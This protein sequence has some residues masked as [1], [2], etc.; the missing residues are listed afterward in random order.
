MEKNKKINIAISIGKKQAEDL[1]RKEVSKTKEIMKELN[2]FSSSLSMLT[3]LLEYN[4]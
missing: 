3:D 1:L 4:L 2:V